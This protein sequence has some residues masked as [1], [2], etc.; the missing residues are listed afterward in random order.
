MLQSITLQD[1]P[2]GPPTD[3]IFSI[4]CENGVVMAPGSYTRYNDAVGKCLK[5]HVPGVREISNHLYKFCLLA[6]KNNKCTPNKRE[7]RNRVLQCLKRNI[8]DAAIE[9]A[10]KWAS[11]NQSGLR[12]WKP[13]ILRATR[14]FN[15]HN[16]D[17]GTNGVYKR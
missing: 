11:A 8:L 17:Q 15:S 10:N 5:N 14:L 7:I 9:E 2:E 4:W 1:N 16:R 13:F 6:F 3:D 12:T